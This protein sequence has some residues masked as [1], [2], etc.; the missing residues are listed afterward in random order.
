V[1]NPTPMDRAWR[2]EKRRK[3]LGSDAPYCFYCP[4][5][6]IECLELDHPVTEKFDAKFTRVVCRND[7]RKL[8]LKR[9]LLQLTHNGRRN[10]QE[11]K[12]SEFRRFLL[13]LAED[14]DAIAAVSPEPI[15]GALRATA[16]SLRRKA[17]EVVT[18]EQQ[19]NAANPA[20]AE[21]AGALPTKHT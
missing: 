2:L 6:D 11:S 18:L 19:L 20:R 3:E 4:E 5:S 10:V 12:P 7:H 21:G 1:K 15:A 8:E 17:A 14:Q 16:D 9:D 13:L